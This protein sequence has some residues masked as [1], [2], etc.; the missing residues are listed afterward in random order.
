MSV[1]P[2]HREGILATRHV[3]TNPPSHASGIP[4][5]RAVVVRQLQGSVDRRVDRLRVQ[6][7]ALQASR[8]SL[9]PRSSYEGWAESVAVAYRL[10]PSGS[11]VEL[12]CT[13]LSLS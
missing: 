7:C 4:S 11:F 3:V 2:C 1:W 9:R 13:D 12:A 6:R 5:S 8:R 10:A